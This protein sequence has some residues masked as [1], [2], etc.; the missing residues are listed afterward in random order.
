MKLIADSGS[1]KTHWASVMPDGKCAHLYTEGLNP[2]TRTESE[3]IGI[4]TSL[5]QKLPCAPARIYFYGAGCRDEGRQYMYDFLRQTFPEA[6]TNMV[7]E[8]DLLGAALGA[9]GREA[10]IVGILGTGSN[11]GRYDG[12]RIIENIPPLGFI[13]G[14]EG[15][16][17]AMGRAL[18]NHV[19]R[20]R[21]KPTLLQ[22]F[23]AK[24]PD[25]DTNN[26]ISRV[27]RQPAANTYMA[28]FVPFLVENRK[29]AE[30]RDIIFHEL[31]CYFQH[32]LSSYPDARKEPVAFV[33][34]MAFALQEELLEV[35]E[36]EGF[37]IRRI[38]KEPMEGLV[39]FL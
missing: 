17:V 2:L 21:L 8:S 4:L 7:V 28:S 37:R 36:E 23:Y 15:S 25:A 13:L 3:L 1:T 12:M 11:S 38:L 33:G 34:G 32:Q 19:L 31:K 26:V 27:Y 20:G 5:R 39:K 35:A 14:D 24:Y 22:S 29:D 9:L 10:G 6:A 30:I 16:G 18:L